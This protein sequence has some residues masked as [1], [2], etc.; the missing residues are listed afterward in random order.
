[1]SADLLWEFDADTWVM[2]DPGDADPQDW[3]VAEADLLLEE[4]GTPPDAEEITQLSTVLLA[5]HESADHL[6]GFVLLHLPHPY[7]DAGPLA[8]LTAMDAC[9]GSP[10]AMRVLAGAEDPDLIEPAVVES[11]ETP[12]GEALRCLRY[13]A[14][15]SSLVGLGGA[16][17]VTMI[18]TYLWHLP[19]HDADLRMTC[20]SNDLGA[21]TAI[22]DDVDA[23]ARAVQVV[24]S[25]EDAL[26]G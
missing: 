4:T 6:A 22:L 11:F 19:E 7:G 5:A 24:P 20:A 26:L 9:D 13:A 21:L 8:H 23:L 1:M 17:P 3:A 18:L 25:V 16:E 10:Q 14:S 12:L 2:L 15:R